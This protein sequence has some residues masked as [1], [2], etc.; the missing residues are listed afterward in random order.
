M[1]KVFYGTD[2]VRAKQAIEV[3]LGTDYE[4]IEGV[5]LTPDDLPSVFLGASL[6]ATE[7][8]IL[9]RDLSANKPAFDKLPAYL[10]T[11]HQIILFELTLDKRSATY[12]ALKDQI[13]FREF[14]LPVRRGPVFDIY[15]TAKR[16]GK[17]AVQLLADVKTTEDPIMFFGLL[18]SQAIKDYSAR[19]GITEKSA[20]KALAAADLQIKTTPT[21][22]WLIVEAF[23]L[24]LS[25]L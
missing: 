21:D 23:L 11:P 18:A 8:K 20:L 6:F 10:D 13:E 4:L 14:T 12:K 22:P 17:K 16:D 9:I 24:R 5:N 1:I 19:Q 3:T 7:R 2:R 15:R 25:S